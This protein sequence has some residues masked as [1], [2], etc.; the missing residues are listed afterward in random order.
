MLSLRQLWQ[1]EFKANPLLQAGLPHIPGYV[2]VQLT[3]T[4]DNVVRGGQACHGI[5]DSHVVHKYV[6]LQHS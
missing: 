5:T 4:V 1:L 3:Q 6:H 2:H